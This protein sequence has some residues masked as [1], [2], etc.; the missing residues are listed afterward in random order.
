MT[1]FLLL[2]LFIGFALMDT[3]HYQPQLI[4]GYSPGMGG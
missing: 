1:A 2:F 4:P 3:A